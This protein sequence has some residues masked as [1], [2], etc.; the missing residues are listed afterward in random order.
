MMY[1]QEVPFMR[2]TLRII[3]KDNWIECVRLSTHKD[4]NPV[5]QEF[6]IFGELAV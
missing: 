6:V 2:L 1:I 4:S 5:F 3:T